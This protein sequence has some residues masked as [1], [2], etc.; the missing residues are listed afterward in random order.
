MR[1]SVRMVEAPGPT[2]SEAEQVPHEPRPTGARADMR[3]QRTHG[4][5]GEAQRA[6]VDEALARHVVDHQLAH[7]FL[8]S[9]GSLRSDGRVVADRIG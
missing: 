3:Q 4:D 8:R 7:G 9:I 5:R 1:P 6:A 2:G